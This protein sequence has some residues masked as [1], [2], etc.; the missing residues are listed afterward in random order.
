MQTLDCPEIEPETTAIEVGDIAG[1]RPQEP[2]PDAFIRQLREQREINPRVLLVHAPDFLYGTYDAEVIKRGGAYSYPPTG[3][4]FIRNT[5]EGL[6]AEVRILDLNF[7]ILRATVEDPGFQLESWREFLVNT[8]EDKQPG[9][10]AASVT[11]VP[12]NPAD[13]NYFLTD[14]LR[15]VRDR[16]RAVLMA[17]GAIVG[18]ENA[19]FLENDLCDFAASGEGELKVGWIYEKLTETAETIE[20]QYGLAYRFEGAISH[21]LGRGNG[22]NLSVNLLDVYPKMSLEDYWPLGCLNSFSKMAGQ[23][24]KFCTIQLN[25]RCR[26]NCRFCGVFDHMGKG[27][28]QRDPNQVIKELRY[29]VEDRGARH[30]DI[31]DDD[32]LGT[33]KLRPGLLKLLTFMVELHEKYGTTW[34]AGNGLVAASLDDELLD[35]FTKSGCIGFRMGIESGNEEMIQYLRRP[36]NKK[37]VRRASAGINKRPS[38][39]VSGNYIIGLFG[40]E[41][42]REI[43]DTYEFARE[44]NLD[45]AGFS[46]FQPINKEGQA[47][48]KDAGTQRNDFVPARDNTMRRIDS[49]E[50]PV[51]GFD[52][53]GLPDDVIPNS[54]QIKEIWLG[55][56]VTLNYIA[57]KN[58]RPGG[59]PDKLRRWLDALLIT[60]PGNPYM[61][62]FSALAC[63]LLGDQPAIDERLEFARESTKASE[64][65]QW[66]MEQFG[67][68]SFLKS[69]PSTEHDVIA[70]LEAL[71]AKAFATRQSELTV[72]TG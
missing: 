7:E 52:V 46:A 60:Y 10:V 8:L 24:A 53:F 55:F 4:M 68:Q 33:S 57:N 40:K 22:G 70:R 61:P 49:A 26:G 48:A 66:R 71:E 69:F 65:W 27:V 16:S 17:G 21:T 56:N 23:P 38:L 64:Y 3:L 50:N 12:G 18:Q 15:L 62:L 47:S 42:F 35:L 5:L 51:S 34:A 43:L 6:G 59:N 39:F 72:A 63:R 25:R 67:L 54:E 41:S 2:I 9:F 14:I 31:L 1:T 58:L 30:I 13:P 20:P 44:L 19:F 28:R 37:M 29:L 36:S 11:C 32:F 45:W